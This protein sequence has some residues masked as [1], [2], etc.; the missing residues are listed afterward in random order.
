MT[1]ATRRLEAVL[2]AEAE[3]A[4]AEHERL[5]RHLAETTADMTPAE[6]SWV[7]E[8]SDDELRGFARAIRMGCSR[9]GDA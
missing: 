7:E 5:L 2:R 9:L 6:K 4:D 3:G 1:E 8:A